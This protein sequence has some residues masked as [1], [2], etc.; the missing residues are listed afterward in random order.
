MYTNYFG[1]KELP[2]SIAPNPD[3][4]FMS[5]RH[6]E[7]LSHL[8]YGLGD[9]G[10]FVLLTGEVGTGKTTVSRCVLQSLPE[11]TEVAFILNPTLSS[12]ELLATVCD[13]LKI[14]YRKTGATLKTLTDKIQE[15]LLKNHEAGLNT[16]LIID[17]AQHLQAEVLE[18]LRLLTNLETNV[19]KLLQVILI[20][21]PELQQLLQRQD[22]RQL[23]QR[24]TARYH[25]MP[26]DKHEV[27][28]YIKHRLDIAKSPRM[29]FDKQA[30]TTIHKLSHGIPRLINLLCDK[31]LLKAFNTNQTVVN[32]KIVIMASDEALGTGQHDTALSGSASYNSPQAMMKIMLLAIITIS[33]LVGGALFT[34]FWFANQ[35]TEQKDSQLLPVIQKVANTEK[36]DITTNI[37]NDN[38]EAAIVENTEVKVALDLNESK[39][40]QNI[41]TEQSLEQKI[42]ALLDLKIKEQALKEKRTEE[43][44]IIAQ[45]E[46]KAVKE[47]ARE[48]KLA[49]SDVKPI[50]GKPRPPVEFKVEA[51]EGVSDELLT[52][53]QEAIKETQRLDD[54][55][56]EDNYRVPTEQ[57]NND[58][59]TLIDMPTWVK[60]GVPTLNLQMH[61]YESNGDG[62]IKVNDKF[63]FVGDS[64]NDDLKVIAVERDQVVLSYKDELF[65]L[66]ALS[67]WE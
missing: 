7:A 28:Q 37:K 1:L 19:K 40:A 38:T 60:N 20:G 12:Q 3:F 14:K 67:T 65:S 4:L 41:E 61:L 27:V 33:L 43:K 9:T 57:K 56:S 42:D 8:T 36:T 21:Q 53:F 48:K 30:I 11:N 58:V 49:K 50:N 2:F 51:E 46:A 22:L 26:L 6:R 45:E 63:K 15:K 62:S 24:I 25:L 66:P 52:L 29:L 17:E 59:R 35:S 47:I 23:A 31:A 54:E 44:K 34:G 10:G 5:D 39:L 55:E 13:E 16:V 32:K 18:Q 64:I